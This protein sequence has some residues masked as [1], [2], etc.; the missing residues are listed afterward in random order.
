MYT[1]VGE[2]HSRALLS[3]PGPST[4]FHLSYAIVADRSVLQP[5]LRVVR[6]SHFLNNASRHDGKYLRTALGYQILPGCSFPVGLTREVPTTAPT[7]GGLTQAVGPRIIS[8]CFCVFMDGYM[9][10]QRSLILL[11]QFSD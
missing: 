9:Q 6:I 4:T 2:A 7:F 10:G 11:R 3:R 1:S 5:T 8:A